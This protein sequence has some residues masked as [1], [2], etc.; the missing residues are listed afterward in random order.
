MRPAGYEGAGS[1]AHLLT[2]GVQGISRVTPAARPPT[3]LASFS[4]GSISPDGSPALPAAPRHS[5]LRLAV[6]AD[7]SRSRQESVGGG[8]ASSC[9]SVLQSCPSSPTTPPCNFPV[10]H[11]S[12]FG[13]YPGLIS[14]RRRTQSSAPLPETGLG[15]PTAIT[16]LQRLC[17]QVWE[18]ELVL[19]LLWL[20]GGLA[21]H[22]FFLGLS[23]LTAQSSTGEN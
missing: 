22:W 1:P 12:L 21:R 2:L 5:S 20:P 18:A 8:P 23:K 19:A 10:C 7:A 6:S 3:L 11:G 13:I 4:S 14:R 9:P 17:L 15:P 16:F